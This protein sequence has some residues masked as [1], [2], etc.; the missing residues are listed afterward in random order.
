MKTNRGFISI[1]AAVLIVLGVTAVAGGGYVATQYA[2]RD[3]THQQPIAEEERIATSSTHTQTSVPQ[4]EQKDT[5]KPPLN[6]DDYKIESEQTE[7]SHPEDL[8]DSMLA[9]IERLTYVDT[10]EQDIVDFRRLLNAI[11]KNEALYIKFAQDAGN[12][13]ADALDSLTSLTTNAEL[14]Q[15]ISSS[16]TDFRGHATNAADE[17]SE[18]Y[19]LVASEVKKYLAATEAAKR[20]IEQGAPYN[21]A[22]GVIAENKQQFERLVSLLESADS[23]VRNVE[24]AKADIYSETLSSIRD[25]LAVQSVSFSLSAQLANIEQ[26]A[27]ENTLPQTEIQCWATTEYSGGLNG[28]SYTTVRCE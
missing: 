18:P 20:A 24:N 25:I 8:A 26:E 5:E 13:R 6:L 9:D 23:A 17:L 16:A 14:K 27:L 11:S 22:E 1:F 4:E 15:L 28:S 7:P 3:N 2:L 12:D 19:E 10:L 21:D